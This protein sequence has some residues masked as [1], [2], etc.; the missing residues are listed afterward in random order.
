MEGQLT[1]DFISASLYSS[2][3]YFNLHHRIFTSPSP[4]LLPFSSLPSRDAYYRQLSSL[5]ADFDQCWLTPVELFKPHYAYAIARW[6]L[7]RRSSPPSSPLHI[8][9]VGGGNGTCAAGILDYLRA[10]HPALYSV[11]HYT[12]VDLSRVN[13][14]RQREALAD[15]R[16]SGRVTQR[17]ASMLDWDEVVEG[18]VFVVLLEVLDNMPHD[19]VVWVQGEAHETR[20]H[21]LG[22]APQAGVL[23]SNTAMIDPTQA[24]KEVYHPLRDPFIDEWMRYH[25][26]FA[27][28]P[29]VRQRRSYGSASNQLAV[30]MQQLSQGLHRLMNSFASESLPL[31]VPSTA[32]HLL[33]VLHHF[34]P[35]HRL[36]VADFSAL[37]DA[38]T[39]INAP[40]V[41]AKETLPGAVGEGEAAGQKKSRVKDYG[42]YLIPLGVADIFFP[43]NFEELQFVYQRVGEERRRRDGR[44][45]E[46]EGEGVS[47]GRVLTNY[48]FMRQYAV[49][50]AREE[51]EAEQSRVGVEKEQGGWKSPTETKSRWDPLLQDY[52]NFRFFVT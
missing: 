16:A 44:S 28:R 39:G 19:K 46:G 30:W 13:Q 29:P 11:T 43:T 24:Y 45:G 2:R 8:V 36:L 20:V 22:A 3:G 27:E 47:E 41:S 38:I 35:Q 1:R 4:S 52:A 15:H 31:F 6:I 32:L 14:S 51:W 37:P 48:E 12:L 33:H 21:S 50:A 42:S 40:I 9:E 7:R 18:E 26:Q 25:A 34:M 23:T 5:Y 10:H 49:D 17:H